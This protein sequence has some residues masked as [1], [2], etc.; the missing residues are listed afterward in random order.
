MGER[1]DRAVGPDF[2]HAG[3]PLVTTKK[4]AFVENRTLR[5]TDRRSRLVA[6]T[7]KEILKAAASVPRLRFWFRE[8]FDDGRPASAFKL[9]GGDFCTYSAGHRAPA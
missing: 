8:I 3:K 7:E 6:G 1:P 5:V 4:T 2:D 9:N